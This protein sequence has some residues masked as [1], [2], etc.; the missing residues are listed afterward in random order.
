MKQS[1]M[2]V[3]AMMI[4]SFIFAQN[5]VTP[6]KQHGR[7]EGR[8][9][10]KTVL[11]LDDK[12]S[13]SI[14]EINK[15]YQEK[16][17]TA[18]QDLGKQREAEIAKVL[19]PEQNKKWAD[20]KKE[21]AEKFAKMRDEKVKKDLDLSDDQVTKL[22]STLTPEQ[23]NKLAFKGDRG[24]VRHGKHADRHDRGERKGK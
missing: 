23:Y 16:G 20:H 11:S 13:S 9:S 1:L 10:M 21:R 4:S 18:H 6:E 5:D 14:N 15:K 19:T 8:E 2:L 22:K 7:G 17:K 12:Q 3:G 24:G